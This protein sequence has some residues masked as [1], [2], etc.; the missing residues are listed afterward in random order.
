MKRFAP[1]TC[2]LVAVTAAIAAPA[3]E[4]FDQLTLEQAVQTAL[5]N[6]RSLRVSQASIDAAEAQYQQAMAAFRPRVNL[7]AGFQRADQDRTFTFAGAIQTP[8]MD[9]STTLNG[10]LGPVIGGLPLAT[11]QQIGAAMA[12]GAGT[13]ASQTIPMNIEVKMFDRD[14]TKAAVN[15]SY[16]LYT[17]GK[18]EAVTAMAQ[19]GVEI[20]RHEKRKTEFEVVR[21]VNK[22]Y[23]GARYAQQMAQLASDTLERFQALDDLTERL[24]QNTSLK[25]KKTDFL[26]SKTTTALVRSTVQETSY[27]SVLVKDALANAMGLPPN[28]QLNLAPEAVAPA[29]DGKLD[30]LIADA[31]AFNPDKQRL[32]LAIEA[33][34]HKIAD[35]KSGYLP[36]VGLE[37][38]VYQVWNGYKDGL[39]NDAN[40][41]GWTIGVGLKWDLFDGGMTKASVS[42]AQADKMKLEAQ[43]VLLDQ[44]L[45]LQIKDNVM[46]IER[47]RGQLADSTKA[48]AF[49]EENRKLHVRAYQEEMVETKDVIE[50]QLVESFASAS[51]YRARH[52]LRAALADLDY[53][54]G[55]AAQQV[56]P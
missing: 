18:K 36:M 21:D 51:L 44:G 32:E 54:V 1:A 8:A 7:E 41:S 55:K 33:T 56:A 23:H 40:R 17:G 45:A 15:L 10:V 42:A 5:Q 28:S 29:W 43:R 6:H 52:E 53:Q 50:A 24:Y 20:A 34:E 16:P 38:S 12:Q 11:Q 19:K 30:Q 3:P 25:V 22:Y 26:R 2:V 4:R 48:Q 31:M 47:S 27:A 14:V 49:A 37:G 39:F 35:A 9:I 13:I 46:R